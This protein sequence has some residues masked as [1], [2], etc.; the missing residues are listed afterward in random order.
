MAFACGTS[1]RIL[2]L[3]LRKHWTLG[4]VVGCEEHGVQLNNGCQYCWAGFML[5]LVKD[6]SRFKIQQCARSRVAP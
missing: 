1:R 5:S 2:C 4:W 3:N 6:T